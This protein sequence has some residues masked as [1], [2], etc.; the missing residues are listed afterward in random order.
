MYVLAISGAANKN[1]NTAT[2]LQSAFDGAISVPGATG[3]IINLYDLHFH[4]CEGCHAC[5]LLDKTKF[6][7]CAVQD[8]LTPALEKAKSADVILLGSPIYFGNIT[9][10]MRAFLE[11]YL[12]PGM[13]YNKDHGTT[14][15]KHPKVG[16]AFTLGAPADTYKDVFD[17]LAALT[18][19]IIGD[20]TYVYAC[21]TQQLDDYSLYAADMFDVDMV[22]RR[23]AEQFPKDC[24][25]AFDMGK[26]LADSAR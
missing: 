12:F 15:A 24:K 20:S 13:T 4:G 23:H 10:T 5:K 19:R 8:E 11:R 21:Q 9:G 26:Q 16:W 17:G 25:D 7:R 2:L 22:K 18:N 14:Y 3:E 6:A 1:R